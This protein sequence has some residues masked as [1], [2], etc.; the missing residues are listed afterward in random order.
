MCLV[1]FAYGTP[2]AD[3]GV[4]LAAVRARRLLFGLLRVVLAD[5]LTL[6]CYC[7]CGLAASKF[8]FA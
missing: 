5:R 2:S 3:P 6:V 1:A 8:L 4:G 7:R